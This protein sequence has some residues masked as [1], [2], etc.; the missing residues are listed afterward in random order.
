MLGGESGGNVPSFVVLR[1]I[2]RV[3][4]VQPTIGQHAFFSSCQ[5]LKTNKGERQVY[6]YVRSGKTQELLSF[7][8]FFLCQTIHI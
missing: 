2:T 4:E 8:F 7:F 3:L 6:D 5:L 1:N